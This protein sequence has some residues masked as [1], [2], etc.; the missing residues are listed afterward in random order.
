MHIMRQSVNIGAWL[1][2]ALYTPVEQ[3][4]IQRDN[5]TSL[6]IDVSCGVPLNFIYTNTIDAFGSYAEVQLHALPIVDIETALETEVFYTT[7]IEGAVTTRLRTSEIHS[8]T[9]VPS[10]HSERM[11]YNCFNTTRYLNAAGNKLTKEILITAWKLLTKDVCDNE[12]L[13]TNGYRVSDDII[14][15]SY[16][17]SHYA[18]LDS[19]MSKFIEFYNSTELDDIPIIKAC[20]IHYAFEVIHPFCDGNGRMGRLLLNNYLISRGF[21]AARAVSFSMYIDKNRGA[22][23]AAFVKSENIYN[24]CT[25]FVQYMLEDVICPALE[26]ALS[27]GDY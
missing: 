7:K 22:Y 18:D 4:K 8:G 20:I 6:P 17:P 23:D 24:D 14:I 26:E 27:K 21:N 12:C 10:E 1:S 2:Y 19:L 11:V 9:R 15:G 13:G 3:R 16:R 25:P 5:L